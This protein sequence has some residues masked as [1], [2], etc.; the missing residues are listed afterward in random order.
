MNTNA[1]A[2]S[3][4]DR[5]RGTHREQVRRVS[6]SVKVRKPL[7]ALDVLFTEQAYSDGVREA[8]E[9][10]ARPEGGSSGDRR[11]AAEDSRRRAAAP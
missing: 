7:K 5:P 8:Q 10:V 9:I 2:A 1:P 4:A 3:H 11:R 6:F